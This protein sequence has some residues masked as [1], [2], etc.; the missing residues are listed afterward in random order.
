VHLPL[1]DV[2]EGIRSAIHGVRECQARKPAL[3][4][5]ESVDLRELKRRR[6]ELLQCLRHPSDI[7]S[8]RE[9]SIAVTIGSLDAPE[10]ARP[11]EQFGVESELSW[12][13]GLRALPAKRTEDWRREYRISHIDSHQYSA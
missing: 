1:P 2:P 3:D 8:R 4:A 11:I 13:S 6:A 7:P 12:I 10:A 5:R 9:G